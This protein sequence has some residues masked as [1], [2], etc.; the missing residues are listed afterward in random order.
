MQGILVKAPIHGSLDKFRNAQ[1]VKARVVW[2]TLRRPRFQCSRHA[3]WGTVVR[4]RR[5]GRGTSPSSAPYAWRHDRERLC[6]DRGMK[7]GEKVD[8]LRYSVPDRRRAGSTDQ[9]AITIPQGSR[10]GQTIKACRQK[11]EVPVWLIF[12]QEAR[13]SPRFGPADYSCGRGFIPSLPI[14]LYPDLRRRRSPL[15][16]LRGRERSGGRIRGHDSAGAADQRRRGH[17]LHHLDQS[18]DGTSNINV[19]F[20]TSYDLNIAAVDVQNRVPP[21]RAACRRKSRTPA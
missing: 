20:R 3:H 19:T 10:G 9:L 13:F 7:A 18:N 16:E 5:P 4:L 8:R 11:E 6:G 1:L 21:R 2:S 14:S 15:A 17:A 12:Y